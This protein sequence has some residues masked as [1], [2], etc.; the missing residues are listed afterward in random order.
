MKKKTQK[1]PSTSTYICVLLEQSIQ[2]EK[3][4]GK[5]SIWWSEPTSMVKVKKNSE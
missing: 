5:M 2:A 1:A 4:P 3:S